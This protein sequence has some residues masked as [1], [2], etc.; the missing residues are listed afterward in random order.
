MIQEAGD[1]EKMSNKENGIDMW[2]LTSD[3]WC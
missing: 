1:K 3:M 2:Q